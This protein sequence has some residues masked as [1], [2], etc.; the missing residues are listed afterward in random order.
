[1]QRLQPAPG[2]RRYVSRPQMERKKSL[3]SSRVVRALVG[4]GVRQPS[5]IE[6]SAGN[7]DEKSDVPLLPMAAAKGRSGTTTATGDRHFSAECQ[8]RWPIFQDA[9]G[10]VVTARKSKALSAQEA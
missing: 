2:D 8:C 1:M 6:R 7:R 10:Q 5:I 4:R 3:P 9:P